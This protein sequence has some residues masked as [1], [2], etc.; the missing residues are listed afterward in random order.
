M[1]VALCKPD[2]ESTGKEVLA[3]DTVGAG[4][5]DQVIV[6][7]EGNSAAAILKEI[8]PPLQE[9]IVAVVDQISLQGAGNVSR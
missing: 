3:V 1:V 2:G 5:G 4:L 9:L 8:K 7:K 6:L